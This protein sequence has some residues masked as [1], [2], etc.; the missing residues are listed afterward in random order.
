MFREY[1]FER[2]SI[3]KQEMW[4]MRQSKE[5]DFPESSA[6]LRELCTFRPA[7]DSFVYTSHQ[8]HPNPFF[9]FTRNA[10]LDVKELLNRG[11][12][13]QT[14]IKPTSDFQENLFA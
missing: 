4:E 10:N 14:Q 13:H 3:K 6:I 5:L 11:F 8:H 7:S 1:L 12:N 9:K 2:K